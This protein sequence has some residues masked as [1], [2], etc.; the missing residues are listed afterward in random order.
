[1]TWLKNNLGLIAELTLTHLALV[2]PAI[3]IAIVVSIPVGYVA[4]RRPRIGGPLSTLLALTYTIPAL[5]L[6]VVIPAIIGTPLR[7]PVTI[8]V[9][10]SIYGIALMVRTAA[11]A[12]G[13]VDSNVRLSARAT[14]MSRGQILRKVDLPLAVPV[15]ISGAR[16]VA[17]STISLATIGALV[18]ITSLGTLLTDGFSRAIIAEVLTGIVLTAVLAVAVDLVLILVGRALTPWERS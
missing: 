4:A 3:L 15:L 2:I 8:V 13:A 12:F 1:M 5:P 6:L 14:G 11:D 7:S 18:G 17:V 10:L 16:V 9:A